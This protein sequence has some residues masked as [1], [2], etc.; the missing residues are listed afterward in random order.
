MGDAAKIFHR[1]PFMCAQDS[2]VFLLIIR[3]FKAMGDNA[4]ISP[5]VPSTCA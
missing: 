2:I 4:K 1:V 5:R 3:D